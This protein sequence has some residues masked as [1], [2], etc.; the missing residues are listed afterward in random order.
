M[1]ERGRRGEKEGRSEG[2]GAP[3]THIISRAGV[4]EDSTEHLLSLVRV[5]EVKEMVARLIVRY[6]GG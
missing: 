3:N 2:G 4:D 1:D 6:L 5:V